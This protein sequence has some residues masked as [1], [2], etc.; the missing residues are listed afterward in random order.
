MS[1]SDEIILAQEQGAVMKSDSGGK[2]QGTLVLTDRRLI[3][4]S[5]DKEEEIGTG[6][7][8]FADVEDLT[9]LPQSA[10]NLSIPLSSIVQVSGSGGIIQPAM[11]KVSWSDNARE[12]RAEFSEELFRGGKK[13]LRAWAKVID[14]IKSGKTQISR[15]RTTPPSTDTLEGKILYVLGDMQEK[16]IF[17]IEEQVETTFKVDLDPDQV[18]PECDNLVN[19]GLVDVEPDPSGDNFYRK[20]SPLGEDDLSS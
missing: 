3:F 17:E 6:R 13:D 4:V 19:Q 2:I 1:S 11:L 5:A 20:R 14:G 9:N 8:R 16:G 12:R 7:V 18:K 15:P 10:N